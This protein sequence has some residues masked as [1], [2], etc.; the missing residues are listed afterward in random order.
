MDAYNSRHPHS[1]TIKQLFCV[2]S[3]TRQV[4]LQGMRYV[5]SRGI[6]NA[7]R[8]QLREDLSKCCESAEDRQGAHLRRLRHIF[9]ALISI[10]TGQVIH[11]AGHGNTFSAAVL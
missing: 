9:T 8:R 6:T 3:C 2:L 4:Q 10:Q 11:A 7:L 5:K 1:S